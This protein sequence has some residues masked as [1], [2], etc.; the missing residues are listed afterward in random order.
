[1]SSKQDEWYAPNRVP[2]RHLVRVSHP[3]RTDIF[4]GDRYVAKMMLQ[5]KWMVYL[6]EYLYRR[7]A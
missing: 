1:M 4:N 5:I 3:K 6:V 7:Q 2:L